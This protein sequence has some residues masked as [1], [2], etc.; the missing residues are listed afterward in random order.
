MNGYLHT[1]NLLDNFDEDCKTME[2]QDFVIP[3]PLAKRD[4]ILLVKLSYAQQLGDR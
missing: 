3:I 1:L 2:G 4:D